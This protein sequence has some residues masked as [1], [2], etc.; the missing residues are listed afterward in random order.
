MGKFITREEKEKGRKY[1]GVIWFWL[2]I[3]FII[4]FL[5]LVNL[6]PFRGLKILL[7]QPI[8]FWC[9]GWSCLG[10]SASLINTRNQDYECWFSQ[11]VLY[12]GFVLVI[13]SLLSFIIPL[14]KI[15][16]YYEEFYTE[17]GIKFYSLSALIGLIGGFLSYIFYD[18][19]FR[20]LDILKKNR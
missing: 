9:L 3:V 17:T 8:F 15:G 4:A 19:V 20:F 2:G 12:C 1:A 7:R 13:I 14:F 11:H 18:V 5:C 10:I 6:F 16:K